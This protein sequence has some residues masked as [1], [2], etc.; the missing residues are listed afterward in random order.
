MNSPLAVLLPH[1]TSEALAVLPACRALQPHLEFVKCC[2]HGRFYSGAYL[3]NELAVQVLSDGCVS[4][5][6]GPVGP[7]PFVLF[8]LLTS[9][10]E[11][12]ACSGVRCLQPTLKRQ[13]ADLCY[14]AAWLREFFLKYDSVSYD[15]VQCH[16]A[17][18]GASWVK[19]V[20]RIH[21]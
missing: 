15:Q 14:V 12:A 19:S 11:L 18:P 16:L 21:I 2:I 1:P 7:G 8:H 6:E 20:H 3:G 13:A 10:R 5:Q 9:L 4:F 17:L